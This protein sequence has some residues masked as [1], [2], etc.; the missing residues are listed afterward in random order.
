MQIPGKLAQT[1]YFITVNPFI[2][3][4]FSKDDGMLLKLFQ[5]L[6][7]SCNFVNSIATQN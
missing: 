5:F 7:L 4:Y 6:L 1:K 2:K 3:T